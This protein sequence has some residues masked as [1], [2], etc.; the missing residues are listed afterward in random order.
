MVFA[1]IQAISI[2]ISNMGL[3][4][5]SFTVNRPLAD[6]PFIGLTP[7]EKP[8]KERRSNANKI[9]KIMIKHLAKRTDCFVK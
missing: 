5:L 2:C 7:F 9:L 8:P 4:Q 3:I 1:K 6:I